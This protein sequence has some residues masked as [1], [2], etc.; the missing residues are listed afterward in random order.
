M[1][2]GLEGPGGIGL[3]NMENLFDY[4]RL[5]IISGEEGFG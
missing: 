1:I 3:D 4:E 5:G 2:S